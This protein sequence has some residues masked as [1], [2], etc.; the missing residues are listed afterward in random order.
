MKTISITME[1]TER[2]E[3]EFEVTDAVYE[4]I[5]RTQRIPDDLFDKMETVLDEDVDDVEYDY[6]VTN[7]D[8]KVLV[9]WN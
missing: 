8:N 7:D 1:K 6:S 4:E 2:V 9:N 3:K 5:K